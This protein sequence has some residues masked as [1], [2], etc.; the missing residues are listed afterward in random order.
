MYP[1]HRGGGAAGF[2]WLDT[3]SRFRG[4]K[5]GN[6]AGWGVEAAVGR[7]G[8]RGIGGWSSAAVIRGLD[9]CGGDVLGL[10]L[11]VWHLRQLQRWEGC[12]SLAA[13]MGVGS[14]V[15]CCGC[16]ISMHVD[17]RGEFQLR[18]RSRPRCAAWVF[19]RAAAA[20][21]RCEGAG[22]DLR[23]ELC[24][25]PLIS[26]RIARLLNRRPP[27]W[28][29]RGPFSALTARNVAAKWKCGLCGGKCLSHC[30]R[31]CAL[32]DAGSRHAGGCR[33]AALVRPSRLRQSAIRCHSACIF[34]VYTLT[35]V[36]RPLKG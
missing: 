6:A 19:G 26:P 17:A 21:L 1:H 27:A 13:R 3:E 34:C 24:A 22:G 23:P 28:F 4:I 36:P 33:K 14:R 35:G 20:I 12:S 18:G 11:Q 7:G 25:S 8:Q 2:L 32:Q 16:V 29:N 30:L 5:G 31:E 9:W 10:I 15:W